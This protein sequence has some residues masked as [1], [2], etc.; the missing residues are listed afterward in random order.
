MVNYE[1]TF[2]D[3]NYNPDFLFAAHLGKKIFG[4]ICLGWLNIREHILV[5]QLK[6]TA[7][8]M[9]RYEKAYFMCI[10][11]QDKG[12]KNSVAWVKVLSIKWGFG[13]QGAKINLKHR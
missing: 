6:G 2:A 3:V 13:T 8:H 1:L 4:G 7:L 12:T 11:I 5:S 9:G 10:Q